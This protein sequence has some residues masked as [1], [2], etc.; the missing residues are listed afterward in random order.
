[1]LLIDKPSNYTSYDV[2]R[3]LKKKYPWEKI[4]H[5]WTLD[6]IATWLLV[7]GVGRQETR[8]LWDIQKQ[9][10]EY[11]CEMDF[12][13]DTDTWDIDYW[14]KYNQL[15]LSDEEPPDIEDIKS[16]L[17]YLIPSYELPLPSFSAKKYGSKKSCEYAREWEEIVKYQKMYT[18]DYEILEYLFPKLT[19]KL[20]VGSGNYIRSIAYRLGQKLGLG[21]AVTSLRITKIWNYKIEDAYKLE[22]IIS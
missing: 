14:K 8:L 2:I 17:N 16:L 19:L 9:D 12:S 20:Y 7:I 6:P 10:K 5:S 11:I 22:D 1:M 15:D 3:E 21:G 4:W 18:H 13:I